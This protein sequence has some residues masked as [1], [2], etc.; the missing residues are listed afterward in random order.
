MFG[1][2]F[3]RR[4]KSVA[5]KNKIKLLHVWFTLT[6]LSWMPVSLGSGSG[7]VKHAQC[8]NRSLGAFYGKLYDCSWHNF[9]AIQCVIKRALLTYLAVWTAI[10]NGD[11]STQPLPRVGVYVEGLC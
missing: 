8:F 5:N 7:W 4:Y 1:K 6:V 9:T 3:F 10:G 2:M 11:F